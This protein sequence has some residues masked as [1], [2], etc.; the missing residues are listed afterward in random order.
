MHLL[1]SCLFALL[2]AASLHGAAGQTNVN[3]LLASAG[4][5]SHGDSSPPMPQGLPNLPADLSL[6][7]GQGGIKLSPSPSP[8]PPLPL[9]TMPHTPIPPGFMPT[10]PAAVPS[11]PTGKATAT[12]TLPS[13]PPVTTPTGNTATTL[14]TIDQL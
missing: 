5:P 11:P 3:Q 13:P 1:V 8:S 14:P 12:S 10:L 9:T 4:Q 7:G 6:P 2:A